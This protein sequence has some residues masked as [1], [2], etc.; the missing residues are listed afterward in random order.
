M[1]QLSKI[2]TSQQT[3]EQSWSDAWL[4][5]RDK[6]WRKANYVNP[7]HRQEHKEE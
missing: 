1:T 2:M 3:S 7:R 5:L 6:L 4:Y